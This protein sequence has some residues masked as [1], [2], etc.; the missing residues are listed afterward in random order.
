MKKLILFCLLLNAALLF[1]IWHKFSAVAQAGGSQE[2]Q[3]YDANG[4]GD[5]DIGDP[6]TLLNWLFLGT[7][8][9]EAC[10]PPVPAGRGGLL[11]TTQ[12]LCYS[13][14]RGEIQTPCPQPGEDDYGQ[15][16]QFRTGL[17]FD[18]D[19]ETFKVDPADPLTWYTID[20]STG[21]MWQYKYDGVP[22]NWRDAL[23]YVE[24]FE[25]AGFD[26]WRMPTVNELY[27][28]V[29][30]TRTNPAANTDG[31]SLIPLSYWSSSTCVSDTSRAWTVRFNL[32]L[33]GCTDKGGQ[34]QNSFKLHIIAVRGL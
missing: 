9:P 28:I 15:D 34:G 13:G 6:V 14:T 23:K 12:M 17:K 31:F 29:D 1:A 22:R 8:T 10:L 30:I 21:L 25:M 2:F 4:D 19:Y 26:D 5:V 20:H 27:S 16:P 24:D 3:C 7:G 32:G 33:V 18:H 11:N